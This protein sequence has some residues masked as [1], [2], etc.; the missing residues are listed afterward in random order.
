MPLGHAIAVT[1]LITA[2]VIVFI[3]LVWRS[4]SSDRTASLLRALL[5]SLSAVIFVVIGTGL[6]LIGEP[7]IV[8]AS[9]FAVGSFSSALK[10]AVATQRGAPGDWTTGRL[11]RIHWWGN[12]VAGSLC[13]VGSLL[14]GGAAGILGLIVAVCWTLLYLWLIRSVLNE[15][16]QQP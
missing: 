10:T 12:V 3:G 16:R 8:V 5:N 6:L 2:A 9:G 1:T 15:P 11:F 4:T 7:N 14:Y 13:A